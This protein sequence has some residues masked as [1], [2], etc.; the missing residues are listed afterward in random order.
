[1]SQVLSVK[2]ESRF[3]EAC[4][5]F[6]KKKKIEDNS[7][8]V[9]LDCGGFIVS[10]DESENEICCEG[11]VSELAYEALEKVKAKF[12]GSFLYEGVNIESLD[13]GNV[14]EASIWGK[15]WII[16]AIVFFP[17]TLVYLFVR[18]LWIFFK[19]WKETR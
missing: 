12:D 5:F 11:N 4:A 14:P 15:F 13:E 1:M 2:V 17:I 9:N 10:F 19:L 16:L 7:D 8:E 3:A 6:K 18:M